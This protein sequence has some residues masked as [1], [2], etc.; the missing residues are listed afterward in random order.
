MPHEAVGDEEEEPEPATLSWLS[1][2]LAADATEGAGTLPTWVRS[3][4]PAQRRIG[5]ASVVTVS[6]DDNAPLHELIAKKRSLGEIV[7]IG[8]ASESSTSCMG[9]LMAREL[10]A[11][12]ISAIVTDGLVRDE[13]EMRA[14]S[15]GVWARGL[16]TSASAKRG[17]GVLGGHTVVGGVIVEDGDL[18]VADGDGVVVWPAAETSRLLAAAAEKRSADDA[19]LQAI[20]ARSR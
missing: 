9:D 1:A 7:V 5:R 13:A 20:L 10:L 12:G 3:V 16:S 8:G 19:R 4:F 18:V 17:R 6:R 11:I 14:L 15:F 2:T